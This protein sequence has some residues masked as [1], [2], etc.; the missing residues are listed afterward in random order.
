MNSNDLYY[1]YVSN[2]E[3][4]QKIKDKYDEK[5]LKLVLKKNVNEDLNGYNI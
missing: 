2:E 1:K 3:Y 5:V 4:L